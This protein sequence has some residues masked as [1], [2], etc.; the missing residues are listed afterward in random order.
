MP[1]ADVLKNGLMEKFERN[2]IEKHVS[3]NKTADVLTRAGIDIVV[4]KNAHEYP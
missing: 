3:I 2:Y 4:A 1:K